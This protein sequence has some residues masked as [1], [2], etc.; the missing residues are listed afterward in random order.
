MKTHPH[1]L[2]PET[3][4]SVL[5]AVHDLENQ[6]AWERYYDLY[7][8]YIYA[9]ARGRGLQNADANDIV[10]HV[11]LDTG[12]KLAQGLYD[13]AK[14]K[15]RSWLK[16]C[17][18]NRIKDMQRQHIRR[19]THERQGL[20]FSDEHTEWILRQADP[21][22]DELDALAETEWREL[23]TRL[24]LEKLREQ[25]SDKH[26]EIF[27]A[28]VIDEWPVEHVV[29]TFSVSRDLVYQTKKRIGALYLAAAQDAATELD[30]PP[31]TAFS[32]TDEGQN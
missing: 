7:A 14:G 29:K 17:T 32:S 1:K 26:F 10:Q 16:V 9:M 3:R 13:P 24:A 18:Q 28:Y 4:S 15:F 11:I 12:Q 5:K 25:V 23:V 30:N 8:A 22:A 2:W 19:E 27:H 21:S 31:P 20:D 6:P